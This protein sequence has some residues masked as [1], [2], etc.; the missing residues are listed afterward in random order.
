MSISSFLPVSVILPILNEE[1]DLNQCIT[2]ILQ[3]DYP[4]DIEIILALG[5]SI[6][7]TTIIAEKLSAADKRIKLVNNPSG[8]T[9][10]GLNLAIKMSSF[11]ILCRIDGHSEISSTYIKTAVEIM[12]NQGAVNVG[13][14]MFAD[15]NKGLQRTI[16][17]AMRSKLGVGSSKFHTGG[18]A[19]ESETVY[20]GTF[21]KS[22]VI[23]AGGFD[24]RYIR[25]QDW[26]LNHRLRKNGGLIWFDPRLVVTY[27][28]RNTFRKLAKQYFQYGR[29]RRV[30]TRQ[31]QNT[32]N[33]RY[34]APPIA[35][36]VILLSIIFAVLI[37]PVFIT[38]IL[39]YFASLVIGGIFIGKKIADKL[40]MP[41][42]LAT[43]HISWGI[44]FITSP[45]KLFK[46]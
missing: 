34:L 33:F 22:A 31:H 37:N 18:S 29:W 41:L 11:E 15:S 25:A 27:R 21:K 36:S 43:M 13:G 9:A 46:N 7:K 6:D 24:E 32:V 40:L 3:Q 16:A 8:Q 20:L 39:I 42:V 12:N 35:V 23:A 2:A 44:G 10:T 28:P 26:E 5:P 45:K 19:G 14:L 4:A 1:R 30:I 38:P 17:Q